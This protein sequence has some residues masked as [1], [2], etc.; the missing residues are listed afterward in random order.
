MAL[1][2]TSR[3]VAALGTELEG[4]DATR[5]MPSPLPVLLCFFLQSVREGSQ[6]P[7]V[8]QRGEVAALSPG[9]SDPGSPQVAGKDAQ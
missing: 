4:H 7:F 2:R 3:L 9:S 1:P 8:L 5:M 6:E